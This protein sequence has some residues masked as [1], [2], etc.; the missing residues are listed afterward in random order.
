MSIKEIRSRPRF[1]LLR[2]ALKQRILVLDGAMGTMIQQL[3]LDETQYRGDRFKHHELE[4]LGNNDLLTLTQ[5]EA[6]QNIHESFLS[7]GA[8]FIETNTFNANRI[9]QTD[10]GLQDDVFELNLEAVKLARAAV[11]K[12]DTEDRPRWVVGVLGPTNRTASISARKT[13]CR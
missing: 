8:D 12:F 5:P 13:G 6:I 2:D 11:D 7:A 9:S 3:G 1:E 10:Y 4:L